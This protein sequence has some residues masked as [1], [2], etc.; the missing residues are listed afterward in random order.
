MTGVDGVVV[1]IGTI[2][3]ILVASNFGSKAFICLGHLPSNGRSSRGHSPGV[4]G[5]RAV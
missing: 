3:G 4:T 5:G 1:V 2:S